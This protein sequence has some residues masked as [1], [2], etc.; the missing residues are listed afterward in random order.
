MAGSKQP[1]PEQ[2]PE[3]QPAPSHEQQ[4]AK[5]SEQ[6]PAPGCACD[7]ARPPADLANLPR[8]IWWDTDP[9]D[10]RPAVMLIDQTRL[11]LQGDILACRTLAGVE[12]AIQSLALRGAP[13]LGVGAAMAVAIWS[14]NE[15]Q[16]T[17]AAQWL[18]GIDAAAERIAAARPTAVNLSWG[19]EQIRGY[20]HSRLAANPPDDLAAAKA[21]IVDFARQMAADDEATNRA[22]GANG[23]HLLPP[24]ANVLTH[25]NA[26]SLGTAF[27]GTALGVVY[28]A[29]DQG[30]VAHVWVDE[31]RPLNQGGRLTAWELM[32]VGIP[33]TLIADNMAASVMAQGW[34]DAI[35]VGADRI[36]ANGDTA[37]KIGTLSLAILAQRYG[38]PF[39][40]CAPS[41][42]VDYNLADG[43]LIPIE[44]RDPREL[45]GFTATGTASAPN[46]LAA[47]ALDMFTGKEGR[48]VKLK[49][50]HRVFVDRKG[51][52]YTFDAWF[53]NTPPKVSAYNPAF[54]VTPAELISAIITERGVFKP[55]EL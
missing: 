51:G 30:R 47:R 35:L 2:P 44:Q 12:T 48:E 25:C 54:D 8:T 28:T 31:T 7:K 49:G 52:G 23:A 3:Q 13:A 14:E 5:P 24:D 21:A 45:E 22:I 50:G 41:S 37:N 17:D 53:R 18:D 29:Y 40:V 6:P 34:V 39:Y 33:C 55:G 46:A 43:S 27:F 10:G 36:C 26:G 38:I 11:P 4:P 42:T 9:S 1:Q 20:A 16:G 15:H 32:C 19:A